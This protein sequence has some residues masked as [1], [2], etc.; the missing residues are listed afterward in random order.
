[1]SWDDL[2]GS[3]G[4]GCWR[5]TSWRTSL[6]GLCRKLLSMAGKKHKWQMQS[7][8]EVKKDAPEI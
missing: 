2:Y 3:L 1:M 7:N 8:G 5:V 4:R 6:Y